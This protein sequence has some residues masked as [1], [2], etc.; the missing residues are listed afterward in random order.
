MNKSKL[1]KSLVIGSAN[2]TQNYGINLSRIQQIEINKILELAFA[3]NIYSFDTAE[4]Y[5]KHDKVFRKKNIKLKFSTKVIIDDKWTSLDYCQDKLIQHFKTL[6]TNKVET[7]LF[8]DIKNLYK[9]NGIKIFKNLELLKKKKYFKKIGFSIYDLKYLNHISSEYDF[10]VVQ[11]PYNILNKSILTSG[12]YDI[13]KKRRI[14][15][16]IRSIFLQ[17]LL[18]DES[19]CKKKYF[20]KWQKYFIKWFNNLKNINV[21]PIDYCLSDLLNYDFD[22][23]LIG[24]NSSKNLKEILNFKDVRKCNNTINFKINNKKLIDPRKWK[25]NE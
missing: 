9:K 12:W 22:K 5:I 21:S 25:I 2:F 23:I 18:V 16:H 1:L 7:L 14:E 8:H 19:F 6:N 24:I 4:A 3:N 11:C 17:G 15:I 10:D 13:L 20:K